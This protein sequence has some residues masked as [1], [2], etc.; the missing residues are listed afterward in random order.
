MNEIFSEFRNKCMMYPKENAVITESKE[1]SYEQ[2]YNDTERVAQIIQQ[3][4]KTVKIKRPIALFMER[5]YELISAIWAIIGVDAIYVPIDTHLNDRRINYIL[6][7]SC[8]E[9]IIT[10]SVN[11][12]R[13]QEI[14]KKKCTIITYDEIKYCERCVNFTLSE[15]DEKF[16]YI[17]YTSGSTGKPKGIHVKHDALRGFLN[18]FKDVL[19]ENSFRKLIAITSVSF[20]IS[21][22]ELIYPL[23]LGKTVVICEK[24]DAWN[25]K[26]V[27]RIIEE[28]CIDCIQLT[29]SLLNLIIMSR[30]AKEK[31]K[32]VETLLV[33][34]EV[35]NDDLLERTKEFFQ[36]RIYNLYGPTEATIW[37]LAAELSNNEKTII[38]DT[39]GT[40]IAFLLGNQNQIIDE[41]NK[42]GELCIVGNQLAEGY[43]YNDELTK[44]FFIKDREIYQNR[45][46]KTGDIAYYNEKN[47]LVYNGRNDNQV[48]VNGK[49]IELEEIEENIRQ[50]NF[51]KDA[52]VCVVTSQNS[53]FLRCFYTSDKE[54]DPN[55]IKNELKE[56]I[57]KYMIPKEVYFIDEI[58]LTCSGKKDR[59]ELGKL[60]ITRR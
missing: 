47:E 31:L 4:Y 13:I 1:Y 33:G 3:N 19:P 48:K 29:P 40:N 15:S 22:V 53:K 24:M 56:E 39:F 45:F 10:D 23:F 30:K 18:N 38:G 28:N 27:V 50:I 35:F 12:N 34:G 14:A 54:V 49:R 57:P 8:T 20:D 59:N 55:I 16:S 41:P 5:G 43:I 6:D 2:F 60:N 17:M 25:I 32:C 51:V 44:K 36:S 21:L 26:H 46:Y 42:Q 9:I 11:K 52:V 37:C 7:D 58:P